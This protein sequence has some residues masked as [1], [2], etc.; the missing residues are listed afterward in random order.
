MAS[1]GSFTLIN[2]LVKQL[3]G[4]VLECKR[5]SAEVAKY[6]PNPL[7][8]AFPTTIPINIFFAC[9][10][11]NHA[12]EVAFRN[13]SRTQ[14]KTRRCRKIGAQPSNWGIPH[15]NAKKYFFLHAIQKNVLVKQ[16]SE[17]RSNASENTPKSQNLCPTIELWH[18]PPQCRQIFFFAY[19]QKIALVKQ[20]FGIFLEHKRK[21][22]SVA[23]SVLSHR[24][25]AFPTTMLRN[26]FF[27]CDRKYRARE[28]SFWNCPRT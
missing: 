18:S 17:L 2:W 23:K 25:G 5:K 19:D 4:T 9:D 10:W 7:I 3:F 15:H 27:A 13:Y 26:I 12:R 21:R 11:K 6:L 24:I 14:A 22:T 8:V 16:F 1:F 28:A 20:F